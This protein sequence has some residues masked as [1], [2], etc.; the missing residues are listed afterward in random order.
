MQWGGTGGA[1]AR[2]NRGQEGYGRRD[3]K[4]REAG[5][6]RGWEAGEKCETLLFFFL[7][8]YFQKQEPKIY[9]TCI[10]RLLSHLWD[11]WV[12][13][14]IKICA[15][16]EKQD[17]FRSNSRPV[18][19]GYVIG[20]EMLSC[21]CARVLRTLSNCK[22]VRRAGDLKSMSSKTILLGLSIFRCGTERSVHGRPSWELAPYDHE[23]EQTKDFT[24]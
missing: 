14:Q 4:G 22:K 23:S 20:H 13:E 5:V 2:E 12:N 10:K 19:S 18:Y 3:R 1:G 6:L 7:I 24:V 8:K 15:W 21:M 11:F 9:L 17:N 16:A